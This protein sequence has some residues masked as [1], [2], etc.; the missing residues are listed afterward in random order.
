MAAP[1]YVPVKPLEDPRA[2]ASPPRRPDPWMADR[3]GDLVDGQP[4]GEL[5]GYQGPD[6]GYA[7]VLARRFEGRL[8][9][10]EGEHEADAIAGSLGVALKRASLFGRAPV[11][12]DLTVAFTVWGFLDDNPL[13][14]LVA[15]RRPLFEEVSHPSHYA[16]ARRIADM[17]PIATLRKSPDQIAEQHKTNWR[18]PLGR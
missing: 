17:V 15:L 14:D 18:S 4:L 7:L 9:L 8:T 1:E 11:I 16:D 10:R 3:P 6:Q 13:G 5:Y 2:Y 12:H